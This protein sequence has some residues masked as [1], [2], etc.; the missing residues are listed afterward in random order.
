MLAEKSFD[1][2][3]FHHVVRNRRRPV[4]ID[5]IH[6]LPLDASLPQRFF[7]GAKITDPVRMRREVVRPS[8]ARSDQSGKRRP[9]AAA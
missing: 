2:A 8:L 4:R 9:A 1:C 6:F 3:R 5:V 7:H